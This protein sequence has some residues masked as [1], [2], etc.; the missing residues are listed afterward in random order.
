MEKME[1]EKLIN[2]YC[3]Q[4]NISKKEYKLFPLYIHLNGFS[5]SMG[6]INHKAN[7]NVREYNY[8]S[9][10]YSHYMSD[11][12]GKCW[13]YENEHQ[14]KIAELIFNNLSHLYYQNNAK[15]ILF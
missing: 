12:E 2:N 13:G 5:H 14:K 7:K 11:C 10:G 6:F 3:K 8:T 1:I 15:E 4:E 9:V